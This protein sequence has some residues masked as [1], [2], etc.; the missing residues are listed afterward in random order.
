LQ[1]WETSVIYI[2]N[3]NGII[4][5]KIKNKKI[6]YYDFGINGE[7]RKA[8]NIRYKTDSNNNIIEKN[9]YNSDGTQLIEKYTYSYDSRQ[10]I[11][12]VFYENLRDTRTE[13]TYTPKGDISEIL[14]L[15]KPSIFEPE[16]ELFRSKTKFSYN[17]HNQLTRID[18][19]ENNYGW[20]ENSFFKK[21]NLL[22]DE[23]KSYNENKRDMENSWKHKYSYE[24]KYGNDKEKE[25]KTREKYKINNGEK[26]YIEKT[27]RKFLTI[28]DWLK[29]EELHPSKYQRVEKIKEMEEAKIH[30]EEKRKFLQDRKTK[31]YN[32]EEYDKTY[33]EVLRK[34]INSIINTILKRN[35]NSKISTLNC[36]VDIFIDTLAQKKMELRI[37]QV[38]NPKVEP[39]LNNHLNNMKVSSLRIKGMKVNSKAS[40]AFDIKYLKGLA[41]F[42]IKEDKSQTFISFTDDNLHPILTEAIKNQYSSSDAGTYTITYEILN[43]SGKNTKE[44]LLHKSYKKPFGQ[45]ISNFLDN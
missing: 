14:K 12:K 32:I 24:F 9:I 44:L 5:E 3:K 39:M 7:N 33:Y 35:L 17:E 28:N 15:E 40:F 21:T 2:Y 18:E 26:K 45:R 4:V 20:T 29:M 43:E 10:K 41:K 25:W 1:K 34:E 42:K 31:I 38:G 16:L 22:T 13:Y 36:K 27:D 6:T 19:F 37:F 30:Q 11:S 23:P 8:K